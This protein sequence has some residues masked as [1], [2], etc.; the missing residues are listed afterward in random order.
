M[1]HNITPGN[2]YPAN[3]LC[4]TKFHFHQWPTTIFWP[5]YLCQNFTSYQFLKRFE[6]IRNQLFS[7]LFVSV[8]TLL[9]LYKMFASW[10]WMA[11]N[12]LN[13]ILVYFAKLS[14][15]DDKRENNLVFTITY[16]LQKLSFYRKSLI[17]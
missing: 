3:S 11:M 7:R 1:S 9:K 17:G 2:K 15:F 10:N 5:I 8:I 14:Y 12:C 6:N 13:Y 4:L 16:A